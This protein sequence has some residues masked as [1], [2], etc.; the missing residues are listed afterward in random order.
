MLTF[1]IADGCTPT[2]KVLRQLVGTG[3][4]GS[5]GVV[6]WGRGYT[7]PERT[8]NAKAGAANK[9]QQL[10]KFKAAGIL[11]PPFWEQVPTAPENFPVL[12]R[13]LSHH[14]GTDIALIMQP[15]DAALFPSDFY[16]RYIP[17]LT[18]F[19]TWIYRRRHLATYEKR[20][21]KPGQYKKVGANWRNGFT[22]QLVPSESVPDGL[23]VIAAK[24]VDCLGL[25]FGAV[26]ILKGVDD[27]L[28]VLEVNTAPGVETNGR[29]GIQ[30]LAAKIK[31]WEQLGF[32][33]RNGDAE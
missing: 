3:H 12:G 17:R 30:A 10:Q 26:D 9:F 22:F 28:Y 7:G 20:L 6:C 33:R 13:K 5:T 15:G 18:E 8:L 29:Q 2:G 21:T 1:R 16:T 25:D 23:R 24:C 11:T 4:A 31:K 19:R 14:G 32:P 27:K